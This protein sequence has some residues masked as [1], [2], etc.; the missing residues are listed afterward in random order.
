MGASKGIVESMVGFVTD[1]TM[2]KPQRKRAIHN[3]MDETLIPGFKNEMKRINNLVIASIDAMLHQEATDTITQ[4][5]NALEQLR[6][7]Y[8][9]KKTEYEKRIAQLRDYRNLLITL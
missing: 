5:K 1:K 9:E 4:K 8:N 3:Y 2:G 7:E 6:K